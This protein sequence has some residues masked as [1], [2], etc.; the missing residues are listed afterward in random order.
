MKM[1]DVIALGSLLRRPAT[2]LS[3]WKISKCWCHCRD[4][5]AVV[6]RGADFK[7]DKVC[8]F[9]KTQSGLLEF[10]MSCAVC[11]D[12]RY[13]WGMIN[14]TGYNRTIAL[15]G[16]VLLNNVIHG[17]V[18]NEVKGSLAQR[19]CRHCPYLEQ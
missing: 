4:L 3:R 11:R 14:A 18:N 6:V 16:R 7:R 13:Y 17:L 5:E 8:V 15:V 19:W 2:V 10:S 1:C 12:I 9:A